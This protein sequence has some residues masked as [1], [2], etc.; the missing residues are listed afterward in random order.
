MPRIPEWLPAPFAG[1]GRHAAVACFALV[2]GML[3]SGCSTGTPHAA[4]P[5]AAARQ[6]T[7][8]DRNALVIE[9]TLPG[10]S[11]NID[12]SQ[13]ARLLTS[14]QTV[15]RARYG[16]SVAI[17]GINAS[18]DRCGFLLMPCV[19]QDSE[20]R[21]LPATHVDPEHATLRFAVPLAG[22]RVGYQLQSVSIQLPFEQ[23]FPREF[24]LQRLGLSRATR[25]LRARQV[26]PVDVG[27]P[28][29]RLQGSVR[30]S[31]AEFHVDGLHQLD[32]INFGDGPPYRFK[33]RH[34][35]AGYATD[36]VPGWFQTSPRPALP[37]IDG[38]G[39]IR[40]SLAA[41]WVDG[42][43][44]ERIEVLVKRAHLRCR[45]PRYQL[46]TVN[47][48]IVHFVQDEAKVHETGC[49]ERYARMSRD[50]AG[51]VIEFHS[52]EETAQEGA[53]RA[54]AR[55]WHS[56]CAVDKTPRSGTCT[57]PEPTAT[58][59]AAVDAAA[60]RVRGWFAA[61]SQLQQEERSH[62]DKRR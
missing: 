32:V 11:G 28:T 2:V 14:D 22:P 54:L 38:A 8:N 45:A 5:R 37:E 25:D 31:G 29:R 15:A 40:A 53:V 34:R 41:A 44:L 19:R 36:A 13:R 1:R 42:H 30:L 62:A 23:M 57:A 39:V 17:P 47:G 12:A 58:Q 20:F 16:P 9:L 48:A 18:I 60:R 43:W 59:I 33:P 10:L 24:G 26:A 3:L 21:D 49:I 56:L 55:D 46:L 35:F 61:A 7:P 4:E 51:K 27:T 50:D 6:S 52:H